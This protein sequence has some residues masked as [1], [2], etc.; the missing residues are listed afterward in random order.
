MN[1]AVLDL[2]AGTDKALSFMSP[3][4]EAYSKEQSRYRLNARQPLAW[5]VVGLDDSSLLV[6]PG[7]FNPSKGFHVDRFDSSGSYTG[8]LVLQMLSFPEFKRAPSGNPP[9]GNRDGFL[10]PSLVVRIADRLILVDQVEGR[11]AWY[12]IA[13]L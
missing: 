8:T 3:Q 5:H 2:S 13:N 4:L 11:C 1:G 7:R 9:I 12:A 6:F 10:R